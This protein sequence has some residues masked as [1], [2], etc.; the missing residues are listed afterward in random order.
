MFDTE[1]F[2]RNSLKLCN[3]WEIHPVPK[4]ECCPDG[5]TC[6]PESGENW[7]NLEND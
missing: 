6:H 1:H 7:V 5:E 3:N 2:L 4:M